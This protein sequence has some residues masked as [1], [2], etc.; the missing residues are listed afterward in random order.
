MVS[1]TFRTVD[2]LWCHD[3]VLAG[4]AIGT[5]FLWHILNSIAL[6]ALL[7]AAIRHGG[8]VRSAADAAIAR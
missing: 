7:L 3:V 4:K 6:Y 8:K 5:H 2:R 1:V